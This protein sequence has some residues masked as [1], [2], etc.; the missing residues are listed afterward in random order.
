VSLIRT[1]VSLALVTSALASPAIG[2]DAPPAPPATAAEQPAAVEAGEKDA[3]Q[4]ASKADSKTGDAPPAEA[5]D[6][7]APSTGGGF[8]LRRA[9]EDTIGAPVHGTIG[10]RY[11]YRETGDETDQDID[12]WV[13][14][15]VGNETADRFSA[16]FSLRTTADLDRSSSDPT[17]GHTFSSLADT[18][19]S[20]VNT[21]LYTAYVTYRP[22]AG[23]VEAVRFGRQYVYAAETF[24][25]DGVHAE[26]AVLQKDFQLRASVYAGVPVHLYESSPS[27]DWL[28]G[29]QL[30][31]KPWRRGRVA[32]D[33]TH[34][35]DDLANFGQ[36]HDKLVALS[37]WQSL[38]TQ[39]HLHGKATYLGTLRDATVRATF[40]LPDEDFMVK[41]SYYRLFKD[42]REFSTE[43]DSYYSVLQELSRYHMAELR[44]V[45]GFGENYYVEAGASVRDL[46]PGEDE[47]TFN[48]DLHRYYLTGGIDDLPWEGTSFSA[49]VDVW[50][51]DGERYRTFGG[52]V[53]K[54]FSDRFEAALGSDFAVYAFSEIRGR[55]TNDVRTIYGEVEVRLT[56]DLTMDLRAVWEED[57]EETYRVFTLGLEH[58]F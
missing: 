20:R 42:K 27:G 29:V 4:A 58:A 50:S 52:E 11:R 51:A 46:V 25:L 35:D 19:D 34:V 18:Y 13:R 10:L 47:S 24:H 23:K 33:F 7:A 26:S 45:K 12:H 14:L 31:A 37:A 3:T 28:V 49:T 15:R 44:A 16:N 53:R 43:F 22:G 40:E 17:R 57:D 55:E 41:G 36:Q 9:V 39:L 56:D 5:K 38:G 54:R 30:G 2:E 48:R 1:T 6:P 21:R 32:L 8:E